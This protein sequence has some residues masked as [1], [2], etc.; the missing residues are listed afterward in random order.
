M[1][2]FTRENA[3]TLK[4]MGSEGEIRGH[5]G[6]QE[7]AVTDFATGTTQTIQLK[8]QL[9][10]GGGDGELTRQFLLQIQE[11]RIGD[12]LTSARASIE[13]HLLAFAAEEAR[14]TGKVVDM[15]EYEQRLRQESPTRLADPA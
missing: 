8:E 14:I 11:G 10:H 13:G 1:C 2:G 9:G 3:R 15:Q 5:F 7:L 6:K 12:G 4:F